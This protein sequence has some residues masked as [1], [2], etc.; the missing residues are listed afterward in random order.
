MDMNPPLLQYFFEA[1]IIVGM[2][3]GVRMLG[4]LRDSIDALNIKVGTIVE[5]TRW[6]DKILDKYDARL[7]NLEGVDH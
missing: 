2:G 6:H 7:T 5:K 3:A 4:K 1:A